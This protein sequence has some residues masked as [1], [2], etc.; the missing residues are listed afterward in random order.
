V[1]FASLLVV[2]LL[3]VFIAHRLGISAA[4]L[5]LTLGIAFANLFGFT[6]TGHDWL[7]FLAGLGSVVLTFLAGA[8]I[9]PVAMRKTW[10]ASLG[11]GLL[12]FLAPFLGSWWFSFLV[13]GWT[14]EA[15]LL[16][17]VALSTTSVAVVYVVLV[18]A[19]MSRTETGKII[20]SAC[21]VT[22]LGTAFALSTL[23]IRPNAYVLLLAAA[24]VASVFLVPRLLRW[25]L[26]KIRGRPGE[27]EVK[28]LF[29]LIFALG[30]I[31]EMAGVHAVLPAYILGL[32]TATTFAGN[33]EALLK[34]RTLALAF[35]TPFFFINA[36]LNVSVGAVV[37]GAGLV[38]ILFGV[39]VGTKFLGVVPPTIR[40][41]GKDFMYVTLL[42]STGLTFGTIS[43][44]FGLS[45]G[46]IDRSQFS[47]L[48]T[49]VILTAIVP[50]VI[51]Q[52]WFNP[53]EWRNVREEESE[54]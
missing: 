21:F 29:V 17:G 5:E 38:A 37:A 28:L 41:V 9:D 2:A 13:L 42:M 31:A 19:G 26:P 39:K 18:E 8:E 32:V 20:L 36:G 7:P 23:F 6:T 48:V 53:V 43:A 11:I 14:Y 50:T 24:V 25:V 45:S 51:A 34:T 47:I 49:T 40:Y 15:S 33:R 3:A 1:A 30:A 44:Q 52:K 35:L 27:P 10:K 22:D 54:S 16:A 12:S 46:L 4:I